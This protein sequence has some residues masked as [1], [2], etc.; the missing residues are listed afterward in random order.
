ILTRAL[1]Y[2]QPSDINSTGAIPV[3]NGTAN[4]TTSW[5]ITSTVNTV[6]TDALTYTQFTLAP[7]SVLQVA[8]NLS[9][10][11]SAATSRNNLG[12]SLPLAVA[13]GGTGNTGGAWPAYTATI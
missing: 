5:V 13:S 11:A 12:L 6:G 1:D 9:D 8:N 7:A 4:A 2:D 3:V 10:V